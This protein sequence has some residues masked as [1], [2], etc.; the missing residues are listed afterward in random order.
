[1]IV[2][3]APSPPI[4]SGLVIDG[5]PFAPSVSL[6]TAVKVYVPAARRIRL[7]SPLLFDVLMEAIK[8]AT[9]P[10][11]Q[12]NSAAL[13]GR[14]RPRAT[15]PVTTSQIT[16][17]PRLHIPRP[18]TD[19]VQSSTETADDPDFF[20]IAL[21]AQCGELLKG[22]GCNPC[23]RTM[24]RNEAGTK[25]RSTTGDTAGRS[26][27]VAI[28]PRRSDDSVALVLQ[29]LRDDLAVHR[30]RRRDL[31]NV[32]DRGRD[33]DVVQH[34]DLPALLEARACRI[35]DRAHRL[36]IRVVTVRTIE[37][38]HGV[39]GGRRVEG[40]LAEPRHAGRLNAV[41]VVALDHQRQ[42]VARVLTEVLVDTETGNAAAVE[43]RED[44]AEEWSRVRVVERVRIFRG[45]QRGRDLSY[46]RRVA[47]G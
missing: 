5:R 1:M 32:E 7:L 20:S 29:D 8:Q 31:E 44:V 47:G 28:R 10:D 18:S 37:V 3:P 26:G 22:R 34:V 43:P 19:L 33:V 17:P 36:E 39:H 38:G 9:S 4:V 21:R 35:E 42:H 6:L 12:M 15:N 23:A 11:A 30:G 2:F 13:A 27:A 14:A 25:S 45:A 16:R 41:E 40:R 46:Q 24:R